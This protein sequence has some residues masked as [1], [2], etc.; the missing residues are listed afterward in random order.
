M[1]SCLEKDTPGSY[2]RGVPPSGLFATPPFLILI[3]TNESENVRL[4]A[5]NKLNYWIRIG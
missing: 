2:G 1:N 5:D 4:L 3:L